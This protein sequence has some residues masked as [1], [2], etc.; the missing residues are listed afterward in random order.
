MKNPA[1]GGNFSAGG[2]PAGPSASNPEMGGATAN[3]G[4]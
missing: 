1:G 3:R 4:E 2:G